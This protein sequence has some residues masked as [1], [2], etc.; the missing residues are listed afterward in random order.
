[1]PNF[2]I[3]GQNGNLSKN[4]RVDHQIYVVFFIAGFVYSTLW[5]PQDFDRNI[6]PVFYLSV[7]RKLKVVK[8]SP[9]YAVPY[10]CDKTLVRKLDSSPVNFWR[11]ISGSSPAVPLFAFDISS[12][13]VGMGVPSCSGWCVKHVFSR[14]KK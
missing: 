5:N 9:L 6:F 4:R 13:T 7:W 1:M 8:N 14:K 2:N 10:V 12:W 3:N 11:A